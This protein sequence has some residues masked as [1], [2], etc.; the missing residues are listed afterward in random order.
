MELIKKTYFFSPSTDR[1]FRVVIFS[2][3]YLPFVLGLH[4]IKYVWNN[5]YVCPFIYAKIIATS[6]FEN[7]TF[8]QLAT[9]V[10]LQ[11]LCRFRLKDLSIDE[12]V[13]A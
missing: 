9:W 13:G 2:R 12:M 7:L 1:V 4:I 3:I 5:L 10:G 6:P 11:T 8:P